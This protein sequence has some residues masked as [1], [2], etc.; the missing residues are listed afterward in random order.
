MK[1][2][3]AWRLLLLSPASTE[4]KFAVSLTAKTHWEIY[5]SKPKG[6]MQNEHFFFLFTVEEKHVSQIS[7]S[8]N[9]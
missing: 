9:N 7:V 8:F 2:D 6:M 4:Q 1:Q 3:S 5:N